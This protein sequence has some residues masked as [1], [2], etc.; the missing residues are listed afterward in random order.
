MAHMLNRAAALAYLTQ[1]ADDTGKHW[2]GGIVWPARDCPTCGGTNE[3]GHLRT[4]C[5]R[6][7]RNSTECAPAAYRACQAMEDTTPCNLKY[8]MGLVVNDSDDPEAFIRTLP[9]PER[10]L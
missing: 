1:C 5:S 10:Y 2:S 4:P 6:Y 3:A 8:I 7:G 9:H